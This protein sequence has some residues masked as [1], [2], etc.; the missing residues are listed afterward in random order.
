[1]L[2]TPLALLL[3]VEAALRVCGYG[4][5][6]AFFLPAQ[7]NRQSS[8]IEN[9][10]FGWRFFGPAAAR[11]PQPIVLSAVKP[12]ETRRIFVFGESAA[13]GDPEP[14]YGFARQLGRLLQARHPETRIEVVNVAMTGINSHVIREIARDC[15][16]RGGDCWLVFAGNNEVVG[17]FGA[18]TV[19]GRQVPNLSL[20][21]AALAV[22]RTRL[23]QLL[24]RWSPGA[25]AG[26]WEGMT[27]F[28]RYQVPRT[29]PRLVRVYEHFAK[30][31]SAIFEIGRGAG[32][33]VIASTV[34]VNFEA[35]PPFASRHRPGLSEANLREWESHFELGRQAEANGRTE[36][37][38][39]AYQHAAKLDGEFAELIFRRARCEL[40]AG[41]AAASRADFLLARDLDTLRF[42]AD[43]RLNQTVRE[44]AAR[45]G[46]KLVDAEEEFARRST[47]GVP[48]ED[49]F[50]DHV[51]LTFNGNYWL[52]A[53]FA[54]AVEGEMFRGRA[55]VKPGVSSSSESPLLSEQ[56]VAR[57]L[58]FTDFDRRRVIEEMRLRFQQPPFVSQGIFRERDE[59]LRDALARPA[60]RPADL[61]PEYRA[62]IALAPADW[63]L[64]ANFGAL[65]E[66]AADVAGA[67]G[68]WREVARLAPQAPDGWFHLGNLEYWAGHYGEAMARF[69]EALEHQPDCAEAVNGLALALAAQGKTAEAIQELKLLLRSKPLLTAAR[70]NLAVQLARQG[71]MTEALPEFAE[72]L[73]LNP[74]AP[75]THYNYGVA[76]AKAGRYAEAVHEFQETLKLSPGFPGAQAELER[77]RLLGQHPN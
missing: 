4:W 9:P 71:K 63:V 30:N 18:G 62:A 61:I 47:N 14:S 35:N 26:G 31:L 56:E 48:G 60:T 68:E 19:F 22:K 6:T 51:H 28:L 69:R 76:L 55:G 66:A 13:M 15:A 12:A 37:A 24:D 34:P 73:R 54:S 8:Y 45:S 43:S 10:R 16:P 75:G 65:L 64:H 33:G 38:L 1:M 50:L 53:L 70:V 36:E 77:A 3:L 41:Q 72:A 40:A 42:R 11:R 52:A 17:P 7:I 58:A 46:V 23:G 27:M 59:L 29:D 39:A 74:A 20:I 5:P 25:A 49:A 57:Q 67:E 32:A 44:A 21:R 2:L